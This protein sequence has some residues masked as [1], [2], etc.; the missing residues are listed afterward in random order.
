MG[1]LVVVEKIDR[2][3]GAFYTIESIRILFEERGFVLVSTEYKNGVKLQY[4]CD[5]GHDGE[6]NISSFQNGAGCMKCGV[7]H[8][9]ESIRELFEARKYVLI[10]T[11][12]IPKVKLEFICNM[13]HEG[14]TTIGNF[15][16]GSGCFKC[17]VEKI[18]LLNKTPFNIIIN[19]FVLNNCTLIT[20]ESE[21]KDKKTTMLKFTCSQN[22]TSKTTF[23]NFKNRT[24]K[25]PKCKPVKVDCPIKLKCPIKVE[26]PE[27]KKITFQDFQKLC[28][29]KNFKLITMECKTISE[30]LYFLCDKGHENVCNL[31]GIN[32]SITCNEC[33]KKCNNGRF[34][35]INSIKKEAEQR[36][37][38]LLST[39]Y[40][41]SDGILQ[42]CCSQGHLGEM[43]YT[44]WRRSTGCVVCASEQTKN[45][46]RHDYEFVKKKFEER[47]CILLTSQYDNNLQ[48]L[49]Y[50][51][52]N[53]HTVETTFQSFY[54]KK[55]D[56]IICTGRFSADTKES[57]KEII[58]KDRLEYVREMFRVEG[59]TLLSNEYDNNLTKLEYKCP[60]GHINITTADAFQ[61][62]ALCPTCDIRSKGELN[63]KTY[64]DNN[65]INYNMEFKFDDCR[66]KHKLPF[67]FYVNNDFL[68]EFDGSQHFKPIDFFGG[69]KALENA[70]RN[71]VIKTK[72]CFDN[73]I[74]LLRISYKEIKEIP[75]LIEQFM[76][77]IKVRD[78]T[79]SFI[80]F[81]NTS[82]YGHLIKVCHE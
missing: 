16:T 33:N 28:E 23:D 44:A 52:P 78:K 79:G 14:S 36:G 58:R 35:T 17:G 8:T 63:I 2:K 82:L 74:P 18:R 3:K 49:E 70:Q 40:N 81:S 32:N 72:F 37:F 62:G 66:Y 45:K 50:I 60:N 80:H 27:I 1:E 26:R 56:C 15:L 73:N 71:D 5:K 25:C 11:E 10:S 20:P 57:T 21:F 51:C 42:F 24:K 39:T 48:K 13:G 29:E 47:N 46:L 68:I 30:P 59:Y 69:E 19:E 75:E 54:R 12:Y 41:N 31:V 77:D 4:I 65:K 43:S 38:K 22:H 6:I 55:T 64:L 61:A 53:K 76:E 7:F 9:I 34:K 67:D